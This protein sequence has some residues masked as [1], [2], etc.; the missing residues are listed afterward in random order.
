MRGKVSFSLCLINESPHHE[1]VWGSGDTAPPFL[2]S[3]LD[4]DE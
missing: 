4:E 2:K 1:E 3:A